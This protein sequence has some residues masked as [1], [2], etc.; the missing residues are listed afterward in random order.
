MY[1]NSASKSQIKLIYRGLNY[2][3]QSL[4]SDNLMRPNLSVFLEQ[5]HFIFMPIHN[6]LDN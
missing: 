3:R 2:S 6:K 5:A 1:C 4:T